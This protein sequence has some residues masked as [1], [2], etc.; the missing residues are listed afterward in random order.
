ML[1]RLPLF[2]AG[3][4]IAGWASA[5]GLQISRNRVLKNF[6]RGQRT[7]MMPYEQSPRFARYNAPR[8]AGVVTDEPAQEQ[9]WWG[10]Y[11]GNFEDDY[12]VGFGS[13]QVDTYW[14][15]IG[16]P[17]SNKMAQGKIIR[18]IRFA[19]AGVPCMTDFHLW[20]AS[21]LPT[22]LSDVNMDIPV[23][24]KD[25]TL[26]SGMT[27]VQLPVPYQ[28]PNGDYYV[29]YTFTITEANAD[30]GSTYPVIIHYNGANLDNSFYV[31][32]V[33]VAQEWDSQ[34][35]SY[36]PLAMQLLLEGEFPKNSVD[37]SREFTDIFGLA[38]GS[39]E[40]TVTLTNK[41]TN[42][43]SSISYI[44]DYP[45]TSS[46]EIE[47]PVEGLDGLNSKVAVRI[48]ID[49]D[50]KPGRSVRNI[51]ITQVN[52]EDNGIEDA[53]SDGFFVTL[54]RAVE[55]RT[56][57]EEFTGTWCGW[58][59]RGITGLEKVNELLGDRAIT[60][61]VHDSDPMEIDYGA[62]TGAGYPSAYVDRTVVCDPYFGV[63]ESKGLWGL[64]QERNQ[65]L[66]E[67]S[68]DVVS[69]QL[70]KSG[71]VV[72]KTQV[73]FNYTYAK[74]TYAL[75]YVILAD[76]LTGT[77]R[78]WAQANYYCLPENQAKWNQYADLAPWVNGE[79][80]MPMTY[81]HVA[82]AT[83]GMDGGIDKSIKASIKDGDT[84][85]VSG[86]VTL[87]ENPVLQSLENL[88]VVSVLFNTTTGAIVNA[89]IQPVSVVEDF[90]VNKMQVKAFETMGAIKG[91]VAQVPVP[92][93]NF[94]RAGIHS[95]DYSVRS[96]GVVS[97][98]MRLELQKPIANLGVYE[99]VNFPIAS[100]AESGSYNYSINIVAVNG[101]KNEA[102]TG[103]NSTGT[104][105]S[106]VQASKR[107][108]AVEEFTGTWCM[109]CPRGLAAMK[110]ARAEYPDDA[111]LM[112]IHG[113][114]NSEPMQVSA[115]N[116]LLNS[117]SGF[118]SANV[119][120]YRSV[121][122]YMGELSDGWGLGAVIENENSKMVE[123]A[124][125]LQQPVLDEETGT[126]NFTTD[127]TFQLNRHSAPY[128]L[129]Y[130]LVADGLHGEGD[131]WKQVNAYA[132]YYAGAYD[133][134][135]YMKEICNDWDI[136]ADVTF[137]DVAIA[138]LGVGTGV[139]GSLKGTV[140]EG[141]VQSHTGKF[142]I[143][144]NNLAKMATEMRVIALLY[145]KTR[146]VIINA[147]EKKVVKSSE[148]SVRDLNTATGAAPV[149][150]YGI[151]GI[152]RQ[153]NARGINLIRMSDG[154]VRKVMNR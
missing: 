88:K 15:A 104:I 7:E 55:R 13:Q 4:L 129:S 132:A 91:E 77:G 36:G 69:P 140:E 137:N 65:V 49:A 10:Y 124:V 74:S 134:D 68:V 16:V 5:Q 67:A 42:K 115:F 90:A 80:Y 93:A 30:A 94:G 46:D 148:T 8:R 33:N 114:G 9:L 133:D 24:T 18:A 106:M 119:N 56:V 84:I 136:Y 20:I 79:Y 63:D 144:T 28:V 40:A 47:L 110:R 125:E 100:P 82:I 149:Q 98:T 52:G 78:K 151:D 118:P 14:A 122:P 23:D 138:G 130:V 27:E 76:G 59:P 147:D 17:K 126:I 22:K 139:T 31:R 143:K 3:L 146:K 19:V 127:V 102:T 25:I 70:N 128:L 120:R 58:C 150:R 86:S 39:A 81:N 92:V 116:T 153:Q 75:G 117:I 71:N 44:V 89:D 32:T 101:E 57:V 95:I 41:G 38:R 99:N 54:S 1:K 85:T 145:D 51:T 103:K 66:A 113:G 48:P 72:F 142:N 61:A 11:E 37:V 123:A 6:P 109:W 87:M 135:P 45:N 34:N 62:S 43:V 35:Q 53:T 121:D 12:L 21:S 152:L 2:L 83:L 26:E 141:Q 131:D 97:D 73:C 111:V 29:G 108:T 50:G 107:R 112:S 60:I 64:A 96:G 105:I 154:S